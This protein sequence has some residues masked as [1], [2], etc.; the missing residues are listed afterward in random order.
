M[1]S[2]YY[3]TFILPHA[4]IIIKICRAYSNSQEDFEDL[5]QEVCLQIWRTKDNFQGNSEW[6]TWIYRITL[7]VCMTI[8][9]KEAKKVFQTTSLD[10]ISETI[11]NDSSSL[12]EESLSQLYE[13]I[14]QLS[15]LDRAIIL[16][17]L[18]K[19]SYKEISE[20][21]GIKS[22]HVGVKIQRI[23]NKL[24]KTLVKHHG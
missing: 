10:A 2:D 9:K 14:K 19:K 21:I 8:K 18:E 15:D 16:L 1:S 13:A 20:I 24:K 12:Q 7:N 5:Y 4:G 11:S 3:L 6:S 22:S 23:K 17:Y